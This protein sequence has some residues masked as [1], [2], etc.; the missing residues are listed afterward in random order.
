MQCIH[1]IFSFRDKSAT[2]YI[3][4]QVMQI[5][6]CHPA[7]RFFPAKF[8]WSSII[9]SSPQTKVWNILPLTLGSLSKPPP[10]S[11]LEWSPKPLGFFLFFFCKDVWKDGCGVGSP[12]WLLWWSNLKLL[13]TVGFLSTIGCFFFFNSRKMVFGTI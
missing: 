4:I 3:F 13:D 10:P 6:Y 7:V 5:L 8:T 1:D 11:I 2:L 9:L 12:N